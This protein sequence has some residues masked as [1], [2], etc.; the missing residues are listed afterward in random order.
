MGKG[1]LYYPIPS[2]CDKLSNQKHETQRRTKHFD[3]NDNTISSLLF[4]LKMLLITPQLSISCLSYTDVGRYPFPG[5][6]KHCA[7]IVL[8]IVIL[9]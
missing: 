5:R 1:V 7:S 9:M 6:T 8:I 4:D 3:D 2:Y